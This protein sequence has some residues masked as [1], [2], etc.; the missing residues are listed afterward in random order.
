[1]LET[2]DRPCFWFRMLSARTRPRTPLLSA[3]FAPRQSGIRPNLVAPIAHVALSP[4]QPTGRP[5]WEVLAVATQ[6]PRNRVCGPVSPLV[7]SH[8]IPACPRSPLGLSRVLVAILVSSVAGCG[9]FGRLGIH[10]LLFP[11]RSLVTCRAAAPRDG[12]RVR[13]VPRRRNHRPRRPR[14]RIS[15]PSIASRRFS[16]RWQ[17]STWL[18]RWNRRPRQPP[19]GRRP[20]RPAAPPRSAS[21]LPRP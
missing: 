14:R 21:R 4:C 3:S 15:R 5:R 7:G 9:D 2:S 20:T 13:P 10:R 1:M 16:R 18:R 8:V 6:S 19:N 17:P 12:A 11:R